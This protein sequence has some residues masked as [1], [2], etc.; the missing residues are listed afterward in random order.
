MQ[1]DSSRIYCTGGSIRFTCRDGPT[2]IIKQRLNWILLGEKRGTTWAWRIQIFEFLPRVL[3]WSSRVRRPDAVFLS[4]LCFWVSFHCSVVL[5]KK[6]IGK[7][8]FSFHLFSGPILVIT[9]YCCYGDLLNFLRRK[10]EAFLNSQVGDGYYRNVSNQKEPAARWECV[11][12]TIG[13]ATAKR[14]LPFKDS[15]CVCVQR[16]GDWYSIHPHASLWERTF[17]PVRYKV[18]P[19]R[20]F[21]QTHLSVWPCLTGSDYPLPLVD[22]EELSLDA[23]DLLSFSYQV[24]KGM[25]YITSKNV[26]LLPVVRFFIYLLIHKAVMGGIFKRAVARGQ[27]A[28]AA[29]S[30]RIVM[31]LQFRK[32]DQPLSMQGSSSFTNWSDTSLI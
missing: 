14:L 19:D 15:V 29:A 3:H 13:T 27:R 26:R 10:R 25:Q 7:W 17:F 12:L 9:E 28:R 32:L 22:A 18:L 2:L 16:R 24:A 31:K 1:F 23:E 5:Y 20:A 11:R 6:K 21:Q 4:V 8:G 30:E